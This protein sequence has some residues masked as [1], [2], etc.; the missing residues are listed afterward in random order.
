MNKPQGIYGILPADLE[1]IEMLSSARAALRGGLRVLQMRDKIN[2]PVQRLTRARA[3]RDLTRL[4]DVKL[5]IND[6]IRLALDVGADGVH[7]GRDDADDLI[8]MRKT[9]GSSR[10][11]GVT[12]RKDIEFARHALKS[13]ADY[14]SIGAI[15][16]TGSKKDAARAGIEALNLARK[17]LGDACIVAIGGIQT[18]HIPALKA[19]GASAAAMIS[20]LFNTTNIEENTRQLINTWDT[21]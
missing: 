6:D 3:L 12:C 20:G 4:H 5:I 8:R 17:A 16:P 7:V 9:L 14:I 11:L 19:V 1:D 10:L 18:V 15:Y 13:G 21:A 2:T